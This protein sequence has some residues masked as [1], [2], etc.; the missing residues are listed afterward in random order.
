LA[1]LLVVAAAVL[2]YRLGGDLVRDHVGLERTIMP[3]AKR[4][5]LRIAT[6]NL[7]NFPRKDQDLTLLGE[8]LR[9]LD[10]DVIALQ[11]IRNADSLA[12][13]LPGWEVHLSQH[14]GRSGQKL[15]VAVDPTTVAIVGSPVEHTELSLGGKL[16]PAFSAYVRARAGG[17]DLHVVVVHLKAF[18]EGI[19]IRR[20]QWEKLVTLVEQISSAPPNDTDVIVLGDFNTTGPPGKE[21]ADELAEVDAALARAGLERLE[22]PE[23]CSAYWDGTRRDAWKEASLL[24][25]VYVKD[26]HEASDDKPQALAFG[27]CARHA[28][29]AFRSTPAYPELDFARLS[30]HCPLVIDLPTGRDDDPL[31]AGASSAQTP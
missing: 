22:A 2:L 24:D 15:G 28:C 23:G 26:L 29:E 19:E 4:G 17:P 6:W 13:L 20:Q 21:T 5:K 27:P 31:D 1:L 3:P 8:R 10:A 25:L 30:D 12:A 16:R 11:E 7:E 9:D 14:G 18:D